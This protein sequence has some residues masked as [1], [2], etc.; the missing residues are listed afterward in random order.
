MHYFKSKAHKAPAIAASNAHLAADNR[1][2]DRCVAR[3]LAFDGGSLVKRHKLL[4]NELTEVGCEQGI[5]LVGALDASGR[6]I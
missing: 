5:D 2:I 1:G 6:V 4:V 3:D